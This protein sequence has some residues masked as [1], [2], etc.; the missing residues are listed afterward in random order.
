MK[1]PT[2]VEIKNKIKQLELDIEEAIKE[3][4]HRR[5]INALGLLNRLKTCLGND[6]YI[7][8]RQKMV[9]DLKN[10]LLHGKK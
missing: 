8:C 6:A 9:A 10:I 3:D 1:I 2:N 7:R 5:K 4:I